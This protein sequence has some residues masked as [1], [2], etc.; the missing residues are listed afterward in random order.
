MSRGGGTV[1]QVAVL[2]ILAAG[3]WDNL[4]CGRYGGERLWQLLWHDR[5]TNWC[6]RAFR[7]L[8]R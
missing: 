4:V 5:I 2:G 1:D 6:D 7:R 8:A 3:C